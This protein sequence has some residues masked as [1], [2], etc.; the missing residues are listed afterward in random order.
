MVA[1][2]VDKAGRVDGGFLDSTCQ[3]RDKCDAEPATERTK[4]TL[5]TEALGHLEAWTP[6]RKDRLP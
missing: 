5:V 3:G 6:A 1:F 4:Q 2:T